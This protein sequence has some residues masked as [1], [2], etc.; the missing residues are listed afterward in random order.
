MNRKRTRRAGPTPLMGRQLFRGQYAPLLLAGSS[1]VSPDVYA[2]AYASATEV[3]PE[4]DTPVVAPF[5]ETCDMTQDEREW[6][7]YYP[8]LPFCKKMKITKGDPQ[9]ELLSD[10]SLKPECPM[11]EKLTRICGNDSRAFDPNS[12]DYQWT[13][14]CKLKKVNGQCIDDVVRMEKERQDKEE[15]K[16]DEMIEKEKQQEDKDPRIRD[17]RTC[18]RVVRD[19]R[20]INDLCPIPESLKKD[21][22]YGT[23]KWQKDSDMPLGS[24]RWYRMSD[25]QY[26]NLRFS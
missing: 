2:A 10:P 14:F 12:P 24:L 19:G 22:G 1:G 23:E 20:V 13:V 9:C 21:L 26:R 6:C 25:E 8:G 18:V 5:V 7:A 15:K 16:K 11:S 3:I 17:F 4:K